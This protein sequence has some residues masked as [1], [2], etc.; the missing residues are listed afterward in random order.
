MKKIQGVNSVR[1]EVTVPGD[2]SISHRAVMFSALAEGT[3]T[4]EGFLPGADCLSTISCFRKMGIDIEQEGEHVRIT[5]KGWYGLTEPAEV[6]DV[7]NSGTTIRLMLGILATQPF[8]SVLVGDE[9]IA[10]RPMG[11]VTIPL[12]QMGADIAGRQNGGFT[13]L[14]IRGGNLKG[15]EYRSPV[16]SAQVKSAVLL[17]GLQAEGETVLYEP[18]LSRDH[19][20]RMLRSFGIEVQ[21]FEGGVRVRGGQRLVSPGRIQVP[22]DISSA[23]FLLVAAA[24]LPGSHLMIRNV[25]M[26]PTRT[27]IIDVLKEMGADLILYNV[28]ETNGEPVA[29]I[30]IK[31]APLRGIEIGGAIIPRLIDEI[32]VISVLATQAEGVTVIRDAAELKVK[33]TNRIDTVVA[34]LGKLGADI[35][36]TE[37]GM[38]IRGKTRLTGATCDSHGDHRIGMAAAVAALAASG[39]TTIQN[40]E[41]INVS[42][43]GF[44]TKLEQTIE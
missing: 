9:S 14:S 2:K 5:G 44:F 22:G 41:S 10:R 38:I 24:I 33:E 13:P 17:A 16:S 39:E 37:D 3:T 40:T 35:E 15:I 1:G 4:I 25:G 19:T 29:D 6:L 11:R 31:H 28:R 7:G 43:P 21:S 42:F 32:P 27:G 34:E 18:G 36:P 26:N 23:A 12:R 8:H 20:E 30:E